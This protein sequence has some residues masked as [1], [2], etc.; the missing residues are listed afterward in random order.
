M[1]TEDKPQQTKKAKLL[2][3]RGQN[4]GAVYDIETTKNWTIGRDSTCDLQFYDKG[5]SRNHSMISAEDGGFVVSDL[6]S[7]NGTYVNGKMII[8]KPLLQGDIIRMGKIEIQFIIEENAGFSTS[9]IRIADDKTQGPSHTI[10]RR[11]DI[12]SVTLNRSFERKEGLEAHVGHLQ[13][14]LKMIYQLASVMNQATDKSAF[15]EKVVDVILSVLRCERVVVILHDETSDAFD[16]A[17]SRTRR[18]GNEEFTI[19]QTVVNQ[20]IREKKSALSSNAQMDDRFK[21]GMSIIMQNIQSVMCVPLESQD[22]IYGAI[23]VDSRGTSSVFSQD[24][25]D[26][27]SMIGQQAGTALERI[28]LTREVIEKQ[29]MEQALAVAQTIQQNFLPRSVP[30]G[31]QID[32][33]GWNKACDET[34]GDYYDYIELPNRRLGL[35]IG[36]VSGH[37]IGAALLMATSRAFLRALA[38]SDP[39]ADPR[40]IMNTMNRLLDKDLEDDQFMTFFLG[41]LDLDQ[42]HIRYT[43]A[44]HDCPLVFRA[45]TGEFDQLDSTGIPLGMLAEFDYSE[46]GE[47]SFGPGDV[48]VM[49]TDGIV[50]GMNPEKKEFGRDRLTE[51]IRN[52]ASMSANQIVK[53]VYEALQEFCQGAP[54]RDDLTLVVIKFVEAGRDPLAQ[55]GHGDE[56]FNTSRTPPGLEDTV[57]NA[58]GGWEDLDGTRA[59]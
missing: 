49:S 46:L 19:S 31:V 53:A 54:Q 10:V 14:T 39:E 43:S 3:K 42:Y 28:E 5:L 57:D 33:V 30:Q 18:G 2:I 7:T 17:F 16:A 44:G 24:D 36:D 56:S 32:I 35:A 6:G 55:T 40:R 21:G 26:L 29:K 37:G 47:A 59:A 41:I 58:E 11:V 22:K 8:R 48:L 9:S 12:D 38:Q 50:E 23:Y 25:L 45:A 34:G 4:V 20:V 13:K 15:F 1:I 51:A 52:S 27:L